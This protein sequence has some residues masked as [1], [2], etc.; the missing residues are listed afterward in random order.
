MGR[1]TPKKDPWCLVSLCTHTCVLVSVLL[2]CRCYDSICDVLCD[3]FCAVLCV[4]AVF[5]YA[6]G[7]VFCNARTRR[8]LR[9]VLLYIIC[10]AFCNAL[11]RWS[12]S[13][14]QSRLI[15]AKR[16][17]KKSDGFIQ[18]LG[19]CLRI[20]S[21]ATL[22]SSSRCWNHSPLP[23]PPQSHPPRRPPPPS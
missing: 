21:Q 17:P 11:A 22:M 23:P 9:R 13:S 1:G 12:G 4:C 2:R 8:V 5:C 19:T 6:F 20:L 10:Y 15:L 16:D 18:V 7:Y 14:S 3:V